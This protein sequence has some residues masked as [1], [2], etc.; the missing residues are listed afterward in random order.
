MPR[1]PLD[2]DIINEDLPPDVKD[3]VRNVSANV[4]AAVDKVVKEF[5]DHMDEVL[6]AFEAKQY[7]PELEKKFKEIEDGV[8]KDYEEVQ[9]SLKDLKDAAD[10]AVKAS[11]DA[12]ATVAGLKDKISDMNKAQ[13]ELQ[14]KLT[15]FRAKVQRAGTLAGQAVA[16]T[17]YRAIKGGF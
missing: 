13:T 16:T 2:Y 10:A 3:I 11:N 6:K 9:N 8:A 1:V 12:A 5:S 17:V 7:G 14:T 4:D 15:E